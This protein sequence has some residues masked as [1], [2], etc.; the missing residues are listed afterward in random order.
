MFSVAVDMLLTAVMVVT[1]TLLFIGFYR[2][3]LA[4]R[5][6]DLINQ[7][8]MHENVRPPENRAMARAMGLEQYYEDYTE[9]HR[10]PLLAPSDVRCRHCRAP[11]PDH[12]D[13]CATCLRRV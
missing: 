10:E 11:N 6:D 5:D 1:P 9:R 13:Y 4:M 8:M 3:L 12:V 2:G 7:L